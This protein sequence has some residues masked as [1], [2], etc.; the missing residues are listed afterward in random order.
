MAVLLGIPVVL[1]GSIRCDFAMI[2]STTGL[3]SSSKCALSQHVY[4]F[5]KRFRSR[6]GDRFSNKLLKSSFI[7]LWIQLV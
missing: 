3:G 2:R 4:H 7:N 1:C 6:L 5:L